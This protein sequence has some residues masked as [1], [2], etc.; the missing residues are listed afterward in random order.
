MKIKISL[1]FL[2]VS[3]LII[4]AEA[5][6]QPDIQ[7]APAP[8][9]L[10]QAVSLLQ[11]EGGV[12]SFENQLV[13]DDQQRQRAALDREVSA[14]GGLLPEGFG[15]GT[16]QGLYSGARS[17]LRSLA[18]GLRSFA[19]FTCSV[20]KYPL[21]G[22]GA[23]YLLAKND[24]VLFFGLFGTSIAAGVILGP[25]D[26]QAAQ[27]VRDTA[28][29]LTLIRRWFQENGQALAL[30]ANTN[31]R[32]DRIEIGIAQGQDRV[33]TGQA[34]IDALIHQGGQR[35]L[36]GVDRIVSQAGCEV[37]RRL[38]AIENRQ[39]ALA[40]A[41]SETAERRPSRLGLPATDGFGLAAGR[42]SIGDGA[43][44]TSGSDGRSG[45]WEPTGDGR[46]FTNGT[47]FVSFR[48]E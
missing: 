26:Y 4:S 8:S 40:A 16:Y 47:V 39:T 23:A 19:S 43:A 20:V 3:K 6:P 31:A 41:V 28:Y 2:C 11:A 38:D 34:R 45:E 36:D 14:S 9:A 21:M 30:A 27:A 10:L 24:N 35:I 17:S 46:G 18:T 15:R 29:R 12:N 44:S 7:P 1:V 33:E 42:R 22:V 13:A 25:R 37:V 48:Q 32:L 5:N